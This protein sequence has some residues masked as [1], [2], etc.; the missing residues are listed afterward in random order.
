[1]ARYTL[2]TN[3]DEWYPVDALSQDD[4]RRFNWLDREP[5][6]ILLAHSRKLGEQIS[7]REAVDVLM[8][9]EINRHE[10]LK[11]ARP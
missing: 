1:M 10:I 2:D 11:R 9:E 7:L 6:R 8:R 4:E 5:S 3:T